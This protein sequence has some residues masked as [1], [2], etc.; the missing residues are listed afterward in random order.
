[1]LT[2]KS[3]TS[4]LS[5][6]Q[7]GDIGALS[8][9]LENGRVDV[10]AINSSGETALIQAAK[11]NKIAAV[12]FLL[13][14]EGVE[15]GIAAKNK[16]AAIHYAVQRGYFEVTEKLI[17]KNPNIVN[18]KSDRNWEPLH[19]AVLEGYFKIAKFLIS[20]GADVS[21]VA[22]NEGGGEL[23]MTDLTADSEIIDLINS[24]GPSSPLSLARVSSAE[25]VVEMGRSVGEGRK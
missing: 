2:D 18:S 25:R 24:Q 17:A 5:A 4:F 15:V 21:A 16:F 7:H 19:F 3:V 12:E 14:Q 8:R 22:I 6:A 23:Q 10:N 11:N 9:Y 1:M 20:K 13:D